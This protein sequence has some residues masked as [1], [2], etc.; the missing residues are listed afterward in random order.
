VQGRHLFE[1]QLAV[2]PL[3]DGFGEASNHWSEP[4]WLAEAAIVGPCNCRDQRGEAPEQV[5]VLAPDRRAAE[6]A[7]GSDDGCRL[8]QR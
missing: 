6:V 1:G 7:F 5:A 2:Q 8:R 3:Y 4:A